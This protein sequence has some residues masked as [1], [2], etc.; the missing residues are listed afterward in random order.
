[1]RRRENLEFRF[2]GP[3]RV[4]ITGAGRDGE[5]PRYPALLVAGFPHSG[6]F[7]AF[8]SSAYPLPVRGFSDAEWPWW[9]QERLRSLAKKEIALKL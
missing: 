4:D 9:R 2:S 8:L 7:P 3:A 5:L 1:M 6:I